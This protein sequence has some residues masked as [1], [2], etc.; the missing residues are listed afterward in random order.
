[1]NDE[2]GVDESNEARRAQGLSLTVSEL[3]ELSI[4]GMGR[5]LEHLNSVV[6][7]SS[8]LSYQLYPLR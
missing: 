3:L 8:F 1:M 4:V 5:L 6:S 7:V 2:N